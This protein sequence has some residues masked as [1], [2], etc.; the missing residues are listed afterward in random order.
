MQ[1]FLPACIR[2]VLG[3]L[4]LLNLLSTS[5][6]HAQTDTEFWFAAPEVTQGHGDRPISLKVSTLEQATN[7][8]ITLPARQGFPAITG[9]VP[10]NSTRTFELTDYINFIETGPANE[11][12]NTGMRIEA[13]SPV[14]CY[15]EVGAA[16]NADIFTLKGMNALGQEFVIPGQ[17]VWNNGFYVPPPYGSFD[18]VATEDNTVVTILPRE[19]LV[20][21]LAGQEFQV[22]LNRGQTYSA[23]YSSGVTILKN[24]GSEV[25]SNKPIAITVKDDSMGHEGCFDL[26]GDQIVPIG[27]LGTEYIV[28][29]GFLFNGERVFITA[30]QNNTAIFFN[31]Q[32]NPFTTLNRGETFSWP[33]TQPTTY[34]QASAPIYVLHMTGFGCELGGALLPAINCNGSF[35][36][37]LTRSTSEFFA[38]NILVRREGIGEF[39]VNNNPNLITAPEFRPVPGTND[40]WYALQKPFTTA[41][42]AVQVA[43]LISNR[44]SSFQLGVINGDARTSC[45]YGYFS[46]FASLFIGDDIDICAGDTRV[47]DAGPEKDSYLW[48]TGETTRRITVGNAGTYSVSVVRDGCELRDTIVVTVNTPSLSLGPDLEICPN[49]ALTLDAGPQNF[50]YRWSTGATTRTIT[51]TTPGTYWVETRNFTGCLARD[52]VEVRPSALVPVVDLGPDRTLCEGDSVILQAL[53]PGGT[54]R[55]QDGSRFPTFTA[56]QA[57]IYWVDVTL[58]DCTLRDSVRISVLPKP[59][60]PPIAGSRSVCPGVTDVSY[61][62]VPVSQTFTYTWLVEGGTIASG[63]GT[64]TLR[65]N[66][67]PANPDARVSLIAQSPEG[68]ASD[69]IYFPVRINVSLDPDQPI[70]ETL[71]CENAREGQVYRTSFTQGSVY[72]WQVNG[73]T[74][75]QGQGTPEV[76]VNWER[77]G[78]YQIQVFEQSTTLDTICNGVSPVLEVLVFRDTLGITI[79]QVS[80]SLQDPSQVEVS[81]RL[82]RDNPLNQAPVSLLR[83]EENGPGNV[84]TAGTVA[85]TQRAFSDT[86][87][88]TRQLRYS[89]QVSAPDICGEQVVSTPHTTI[90]LEAQQNPGS[91]LVSLSWSAY[92][93][94]P[95]GV[96]GYEIWQAL[97]GGTLVRIA[98]VPAN[99]LAWQAEIGAQG[100]SHTY[101]VRAV[102]PGEAFSFSNPV[103]FEFDHELTIPNVFTPNGDQKNDRFEVVKIQLF[104]ENFLVVY[105]RWGKKVFEQQNYLN[106]W[107]ADGLTNGVYYYELKTLRPEKVYKGYVQI[108][109]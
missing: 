102:G 95:E 8:R 19:N 25:R 94:W 108:M 35:Q 30:T 78:Q 4:L 76:T 71:I 42:I 100:F 28:V 10:A 98:T 40:E 96:T 12:L 5:Y 105:N 54:Y 16:N 34:I 32:A 77:I 53:N 66:W 50:S 74:V 90:L 23:R 51:V 3:L 97:E 103:N 49:S 57:G 82:L 109:R 85:R 107:Q 46:S 14:S 9:F 7:I 65:V 89:Y 6:L 13:T 38:L 73:G 39:L 11:I 26:F 59:V 44:R 21:Y 41:Q 79:S 2:W 87:L 48:S 56:K 47:L 69:T 72:Q 18:I 33:I 36:I 75:V 1:Q 60:A 80:V 24:P 106:T 84:I 70:G 86:G 31:G 45:R 88:A 93:G 22:F 64:Q 61:T 101:R 83:Q 55:W 29:Q 63:Q 104:P 52:S 37:G 58:G 92:E 20:G 68:C 27:V 99:T 17:N 43:S 15:Y 81:W 91:D 67:G 62:F